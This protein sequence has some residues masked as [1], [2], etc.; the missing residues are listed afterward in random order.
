MISYIFYKT[1]EKTTTIP[2]VSNSFPGRKYMF[3]KCQKAFPY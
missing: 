2:L 3:D 1:Y